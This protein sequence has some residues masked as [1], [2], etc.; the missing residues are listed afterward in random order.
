M[1]ED[2]LN[3]L[4]SGGGAGQGLYDFAELNL[5]HDAEDVTL[6]FE[7]IEE[8]FLAYVGGLG[9]VFDGDVLE[10][11]FGEE[12]EG[13]AEEADAGFGGAALAAACGLRMRSPAV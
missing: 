7:V 9:D 4:S 13:A 10:T 1:V 6:G 12:L 11:A 8:G 2:R 5:G 3:L